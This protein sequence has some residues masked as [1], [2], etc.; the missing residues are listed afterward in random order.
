MINAIILVQAVTDRITELSQ[1]IADL[2]SVTEV[3]SFA[4]KEADLIAI[5]RAIDH[6]Q[7]VDIADQVSKNHGVLGANTHIAHRHYSNR[8]V[9]AGFSIGFTSPDPEFL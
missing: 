3:Y 5:I 9:Q 8:D 2:P 6:E 1:K 4:R 7:L